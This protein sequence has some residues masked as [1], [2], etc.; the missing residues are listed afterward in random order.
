MSKKSPL[1]KNQKR[2]KFTVHPSLFTENC[3]VIKS[4]TNIVPTERRYKFKYLFFSDLFFLDTK[5]NNKS[6]IRQLF[7]AKN[8]FLNTRNLWLIKFNIFERMI[9]MF[10]SQSSC[11]GERSEWMLLGFKYCRS[12][13][14]SLLM[15]NR[16]LRC[17]PN[18]RF[19]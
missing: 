5:S 17:A 18:D 4:Q 3:S 8:R 16:L 15:F 2:Q 1:K 6:W 14:N 9:K 7:E 11:R 10:T 12:L 19:C 13:E